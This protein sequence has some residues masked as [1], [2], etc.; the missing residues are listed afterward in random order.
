M[1]NPTQVSHVIPHLV[2]NDAAAALDFYAK[3]FDAVEQLRMPGP[4]GKLMHAS[5]SFGGNMVMLVDEFPEM[6]GKSPKTLGGSPVTLHLV[7]GN[8]DEAIARAEAAGATVLM[9]AADQFWG[10]RYGMVQDPFGH[11]WSIAHPLK[12]MSNDEMKAAGA[13]MMAKA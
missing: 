2:V 5:M 10:D 7:V 13:A 3:A 8:A 9:P 12:Q 4:N 6:G 1:T 11:S